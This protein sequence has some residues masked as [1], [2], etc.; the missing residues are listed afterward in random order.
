MLAVRLVKCRDSCCDWLVLRHERDAVS[1]MHIHA[2]CLVTLDGDE[3]MGTVRILLSTPPLAGDN[4]IPGWRRVGRRRPRELRG[5]S[6]APRH[7]LQVKLLDRR[8]A[9]GRG[10]L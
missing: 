2:V 5:Q 10:A 9:D 1:R 7:V 8:G 4:F 6:S 3:R